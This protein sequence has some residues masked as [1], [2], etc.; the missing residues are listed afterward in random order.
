MTEL[1]RHPPQVPSVWLRIGWDQY[2]SSANGSV[3]GRRGR[4][5]QAR[6]C[7]CP[8]HGWPHQPVPLVERSIEPKPVSYTQ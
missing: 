5:H 7:S 4:L 1:R 6:S 3:K 2:L 8:R